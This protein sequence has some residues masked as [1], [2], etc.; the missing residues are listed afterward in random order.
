[1]APGRLAWDTWSAGLRLGL[2]PA[3]GPPTSWHHPSGVSQT[4][5]K[6]AAQC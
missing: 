6:G 3:P 2:S 5:C 1:L 4:E